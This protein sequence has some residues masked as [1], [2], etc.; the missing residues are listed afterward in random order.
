MRPSSSVRPSCSA[1]RRNSCLRLLRSGDQGR[2]LSLRRKSDAGLSKRLRV[3]RP[4]LPQNGERRFFCRR[5]GDA[6]KDD[7]R[8]WRRDRHRR[9]TRHGARRGDRSVDRQHVLAFALY[10]RCEAHEWLR[11]VRHANLRARQLLLRHEVELAVR[12]RGHL[13]LQSELPLTR[14]HRP[15]FAKTAPSGN[16]HVRNR[17]RGRV[18]G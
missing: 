15:A 9:C 5:S 11:P 6:A 12:S 14:I 1:R 10:E 13:D 18:R 8:R 2:R 4:A 17:E 7:C 3:C 16:L